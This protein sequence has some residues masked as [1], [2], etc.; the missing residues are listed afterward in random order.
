MNL[1]IK[2]RESFRPF[3]P[4]VIREE[5]F[6]WF[7]FEKFKITKSFD[8]PYMLLVGNVNSFTNND[9]KND[10]EGFK[11]LKQIKSKIPAVTHIN[12]SAR[13]QTVDKKS[14]QKLYN[15]LKEFKRISGC[16]ILINTSFNVRGEPI[17]ESPEDAY[18]CFMRTDMDYLVLGNYILE[19]KLQPEFVEHTNWRE[20]FKL[21]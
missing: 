9:S 11:K 1:K 18:R 2:Y 5:A 6:N 14:N 21:D 15:L 8:S 13:I 16:P 10:C 20:E 19:K 17:V 3:A 7:N 4:I 12:G